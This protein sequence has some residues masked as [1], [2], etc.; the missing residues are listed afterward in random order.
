[1]LGSYFLKT[2][3]ILWL[4]GHSSKSWVGLRGLASIIVQ[5]LIHCE[6]L[7]DLQVYKSEYNDFVMSAPRDIR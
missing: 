4:F 1:M 7:V 5:S 6:T 3:I 2:T